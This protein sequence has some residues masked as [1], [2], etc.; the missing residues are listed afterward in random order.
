MTWEGWIYA[1]KLAES[2]DL[3]YIHL[4]ISNQQFVRAST[5]FL[6]YRNATDAALVFPS[7]DG[8]D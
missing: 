4:D 5:D 2:T 1:K 7:D 6:H 3:P 8:K